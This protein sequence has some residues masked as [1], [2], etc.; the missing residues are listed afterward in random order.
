VF[1]VRKVGQQKILSNQRKN[2]LGFHKSVFFLFWAE[3][4]L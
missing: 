3:N 2:W 4:T 1:A